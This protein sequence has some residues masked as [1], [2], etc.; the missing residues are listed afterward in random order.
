MKHSIIAA[1]MF[2]S[3]AAGSVNA[4]SFLTL[5]EKAEQIQAIR[6]EAN[7]AMEADK[8]ALD[9]YNNDRANLSDAQIKQIDATM[10]RAEAIMNSAQARIDAIRSTP[11]APDMPVQKTPVITGTTYRSYITSL[12]AV[13]LS[14]KMPTN[15]TIKKSVGDLPDS[16]K[17]KGTVKG[18]NIE[19]T[20]KDLKKIDPSI[21]VDVPFNSAFMRSVKGNNH[22]DTLR[23]A[24][25]HSTG[26]GANNAKASR[27]A[28]GFSTRGSHIGGGST[29]GGF[30]Y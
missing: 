17:L 21:Q 8:A 20:A 16:T 9:T 11:L 23:S 10:R 22:K 24:D 19:L 15:S 4:A 14:Q 28:G 3:V 26:N 18:K 12:Q 6:D 2:C 29:G 13:S 5:Q 1:A 25:E 27:S 30:N 7:K